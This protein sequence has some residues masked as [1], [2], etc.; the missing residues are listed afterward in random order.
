MPSG[1]P[2]SMFSA[3]HPG[4]PG[5]VADGPAD[6]RLKAREMIDRRMPDGVINFV[7]GSGSL[8]HSQEPVTD[9]GAVTWRSAVTLPA[10]AEMG[11]EKPKSK[12][13][14]TIWPPDPVPI[15]TQSSILLTVGLW[16]G[17]KRMVVGP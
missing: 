6:L 7:P 14:S 15:F 3:P 9:A 16:P 17:W 4:R 13:W 5:G 1:L 8:I 11:S 12:M 10:L 2:G